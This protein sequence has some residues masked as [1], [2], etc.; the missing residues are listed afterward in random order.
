MNAYLDIFLVLV[1]VIGGYLY[2]KNK[3]KEQKD[4]L[5]VD[6]YGDSVLYGYGVAKSPIT[7][8]KELKPKWNIIDHTASGLNTKDLLNGYETPDPGL[9]QKYWINGPQK[10][11][12]QI[13]RSGVDVVVIETGFNDAFKGVDDYEDHLRAVVQIAVNENKKVVITGV[14]RVE[15]DVPMVNV[16]NEISLRIAKEFNATH[17]GWYEDYQGAVDVAEDTVH[18]TQQASDRMTARLIEAIEKAYNSDNVQS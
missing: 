5:T 12:N 13:D 7:L 1:I 17:A 16:Y 6:L 18:R 3:I 11:F 2:T 15:I 8:M 4:E 14:F 10:P 9:D